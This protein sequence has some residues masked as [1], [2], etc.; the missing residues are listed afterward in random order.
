MK[1]EIY[2]QSLPFIHCFVQYLN[3]NVYTEIESLKI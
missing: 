3:T 1:I 2:K